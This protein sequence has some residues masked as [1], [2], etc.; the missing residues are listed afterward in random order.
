MYNSPAVWEYCELVQFVLQVREVNAMEDADGQTQPSEACS[1]NGELPDPH[2]RDAGLLY[3]QYFF[4][5]IENRALPHTIYPD[6]NFSSFH[7]P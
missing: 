7:S 5:F 4:P 6:Y 3:K 2:Y 1:E